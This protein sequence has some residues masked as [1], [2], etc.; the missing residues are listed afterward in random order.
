YHLRADAVR[1]P[2]QQVDREGS[3]RQGEGSDVEPMVAAL[4]LLGARAP[5]DRLLDL[6][7]ASD[8]E[9][10]QQGAVVRQEQGEALVELAEESD[11]QGRGGRR[12]SEG[13]TAGDH[14]VTQGAAAVRETG[15]PNAGGSAYD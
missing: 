11:V 9:R 1:R 3:A 15:R 8:A 6:L 12:R 13:R 2:R 4:V 5:D 10:R 7:H 14:R